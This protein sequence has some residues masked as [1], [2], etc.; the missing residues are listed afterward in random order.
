M[1]EAVKGRLK[2]YFQTAFAFLNI[3]NIDIGMKSE[4]VGLSLRATTR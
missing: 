3:L 1:L 4:N 2:V